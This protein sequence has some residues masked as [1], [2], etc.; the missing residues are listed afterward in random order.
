VI[1]VKSKKNYKLSLIIV[2]SLVVGLGVIGYQFVNRKPSAGYLSDVVSQ[3]KIINYY[4]FTGVVESSNIHNVKSINSMKIKE[5]YIKE[6]S[7]VKVGSRL[8]KMLDGTYVKSKVNGKVINM[9]VEDEQMV[10]SGSPLCDIYDLT[11]KQI[12]IK[13][14]EHDLKSIKVNSPIEIS[15]SALDLTIQ[16]KVKSID[17]IGVNQNGIAYYTAKVTIDKN[18]DIKIGMTAEGKIINQQVDDVLAIPVLALNIEGNEPP[19]VFVL[20]DATKANS[21]LIK[22]LVTIGINDGKYIQIVDGLVLGQKVFFQA[23]ESETSR[24]GPP[25]R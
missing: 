11:N 3:Q 5:V 4:T 17:D 21:K 1:K 22:Q 25:S 16:G 9:F 2:F 23:V 18:D 14:D 13:I 24:F 7:V 10:G 19:F 15:I 20:E 12:V 6:G 8:F